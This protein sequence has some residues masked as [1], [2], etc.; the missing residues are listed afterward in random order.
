VGRGLAVGALVGHHGSATVEGLRR[1]NRM[2]CLSA[3]L[4]EVLEGG[5]RHGYALYDV[6]VS[7]GF[8][9][10]DRALVYHELHVLE[11]TGLV[12]SHLDVS[13][14]GPARRVYAVTTAG[15]QMLVS[16]RR[17]GAASKDR[18]VDV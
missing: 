14:P 16:T 11:R 9:M 6:L 15:R 8:R 17:E 12:A 3:A 5:P 13:S 10:G 18:A 1:G 2:R 4:L 7:S